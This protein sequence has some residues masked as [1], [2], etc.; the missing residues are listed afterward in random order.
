MC[1]YVDMSMCLYAY[2]TICLY[3][4]MYIC[5]CVYMYICIYV[6]MYICIYVYMY[7][8]LGSSFPGGYAPINAKRAS[9]T[10]P[11]GLQ[12]AS[13]NM[14]EAPQLTVTEE[15]ANMQCII[16]MNNPPKGDRSEGISIYFRRILIKIIY[17]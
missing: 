6:Y 3:V 14:P 1:L 4:C 2:M 8:L 16:M 13:F 15:K 5:I 11:P 17:F 9:L 10:P 7:I 12:G